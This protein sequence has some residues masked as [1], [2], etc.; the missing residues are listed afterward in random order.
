M[1]YDM[2]KNGDIFYFVH[3]SFCSSIS[4]IKENG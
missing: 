3:F 2:I 1:S 4:Y